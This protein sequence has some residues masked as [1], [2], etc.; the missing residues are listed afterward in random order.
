MKKLFK[1]LLTVLVL[2]FGVLFASPYLFK[3][4]IIA[5]VKKSIN[6]NLNAKVDFTDVDLSLIKN[7]PNATVGIKN[8]SVINLAPFAGDT[9]FFGETVDLKMSIS[10]LFKS[11]N[12]QL[13]IDE[14]KLKNSKCNIIFNEAGIGNFDVAIKKDDEKPAESKAMA[15]ELTKYAIE[16]MTFR[17]LDK[18]SQIDFLISDINHEGKGNMAQDILDLKTNT[19]AMISFSKGNT[20]FIN[21]LALSLDAIIGIDSKNMKFTFK[22]NKALLNQLPLNFEG[23]IQMIENGQRYDLKFDAPSSDFYH[24]LGLI[25][26]SFKGE[27]NKIQSSGKLSLGGFVKGDM[28]NEKIPTFD[29]HIMA[30][31]AS[32]KF[33]DF[34][35]KVENIQINSTIINK[36][37]FLNDTEI[38]INPLTFKIDQDV[39]DLKT[40]LRNLMENPNVDAS[41]KGRLNLANLSK[42][43]PV[44]ISYPLSGL[45]TADV[46]TKFDMKS[47]ETKAYQNIKS[48]GTLQIN[49]FDYK[50]ENGKLM[51]IKMAKLNFTPSQLNLESFEAKTGKSDISVTGKLENFFGYLFNNQIITGNFVANSNAF[52]VSDFMNTK[53]KDDTKKETVNKQSEPLKIPKNIDFSL[54]A[55]AKQVFYDNLVL[56]N[57]NGKLALKEQSIKLENVLTDIFDGQIGFNG[58]VSTKETM[59]DFQMNLNLN[60]L[61]IAES[62]SK[63][64]FMEKILPI[65][66]SIN[67]KLTSKVNLSGKLDNQMSPQI[68]TIS[69]DLLGQLLST[70]INTSNTKILEKLSSQ[71][72]FFDPKKLNLN[73]IKA[74]LTFDKGRVFVKPFNLKY[75]DINIIVGGDHGFDQSMNYNIKFDVPAKYLGSE[76]NTALAKLSPSQTNNLKSIPINALVVG[77]FKNPTVTTD[78]KSASTN[79]AN[80]LIKEQKDKLLNQGSQQAGKLLDGFRKPGDTTKTVIPTSKAEINQKLEEEKKRLE[81]Q[82]KQKAKEEAEKQKKKLLDKLFGN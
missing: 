15:F 66:K 70:T 42:A 20:N 27:L 35:K 19:K 50:D 71:L 1:I 9:L 13:K 3:D 52:Y 61:N 21:K 28:I 80:H 77:T 73:D 4:K 55:N 23:F 60:A 69:G 6:E 31:N 46:E 39:F 59:P 38:N 24:F 41:L 64:S 8:L 47:V 26:S 62:C 81:E 40:I 17:F 82:A 76:I 29:V 7:F 65:A 34:P 36:T 79:L 12:E 10:Q 53:S 37:G 51:A 25:P 30:N 44:D 18:K 32:F 33:P 56:K 57:V 49:G 67:G 58:F 48:N 11:E 22:E 43:Y 75:Q 72:K 74:S 68:N 78:L 5:F 16:N 14:F 63:L 54:Q 2:S 45:L